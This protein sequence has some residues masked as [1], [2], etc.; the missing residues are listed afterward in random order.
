MWRGGQEVRG[1]SLLSSLQ[2]YCELKTTL[3]HKVLIAN[4]F[5]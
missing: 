4:K 3:K 5:K 1:K 2:F